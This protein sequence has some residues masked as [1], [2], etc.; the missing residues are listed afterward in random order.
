MPRPKDSATAST[1]L[2]STPQRPAGARGA[3]F[4]A[5]VA[6]FGALW[7][8]IEITLGSFLNTLRIP[9]GGTLLASLGAM[10]LVAA[11][12][13]MPRRGASIATGVVAALCKS[14]SPGGIILGPMVA[15]TVEALLVEVALL[16]APRARA[17]AAAAGVLAATWSTFQKV[18]SQVVFFGAGVITLY[19]TA[20]RRARDWLGLP[21]TAGW[22]ALFALLAIVAALGAAAGLAGRRIGAE[23]VE[24]LSLEGELARER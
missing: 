15:I 5:H 7:G 2:R 23:S 10:L 21:L 14:I 6:A 20:L 1:E 3:Q 9:F 8:S 4:W 13:I 17:S 18:I 16:V 11:R 22:W 19:L 12:Q 24:R